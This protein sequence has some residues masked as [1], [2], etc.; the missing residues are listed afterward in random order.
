MMQDK[1]H[2]QEYDNLMRDIPIY[3]GEIMEL[4]RLA[5]TNRKGSFI[6]S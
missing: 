2:R 5:V 6:N 3:D 1:T 4:A